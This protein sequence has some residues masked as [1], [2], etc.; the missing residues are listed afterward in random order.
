MRELADNSFLLY[1]N[2]SSVP[3]RNLL[4]EARLYNITTY[5]G[6]NQGRQDKRYGAPRRGV[7]YT[8]RTSEKVTSFTRAC[9]KNLVAVRCPLGDF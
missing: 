8:V 1:L 7:C 9:G 4:A 6:T 3:L 5:V 2:F